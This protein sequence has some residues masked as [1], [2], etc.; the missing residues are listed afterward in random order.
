MHLVTKA[1]RRSCVAML[2]AS[3]GIWAGPVRSVPAA[4]EC[5]PPATSVVGVDA[6]DARTVELQDGR[7]IRLAGIETFALLLDQADSAEAALRRRVGAIVGGR[8][9]RLAEIGTPADRH[10]R[11]PALVTSENGALV[12]EQLVA[13]GLAIAFAVGEPLPCF[14][15]LLTAEKEARQAGKGLW[16]KEPL[17]RARPQA[18]RSRIG[19]FALFEGTV[20]SVG[21]RPGRTY[22]NFGEWWSEDVTAEID[23]RDRARFGGE[24]E[25]QKLTGKRVRIRGFIEDKEG[26]M[27]L[28]NSPMQLEI[29]GDSAEG[30]RP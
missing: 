1:A 4:P 30:D 16:T 5:L 19:R 25:L 7:V 22:L 21:N 27:V 2:A 28:V 8:P 13:D 11:L 3:F 14:D 24:A 17:P 20:I 15:R 26:P 12:Q 23:V 6:P 18:L 29:L 10:G 9:L